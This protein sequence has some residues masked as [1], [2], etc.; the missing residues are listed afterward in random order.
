MFIHIYIFALREIG[1]KNGLVCLMIHFNL[2]I[3]YKLTVILYCVQ[4]LDG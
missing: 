1:I 3:G 2:Y 4:K